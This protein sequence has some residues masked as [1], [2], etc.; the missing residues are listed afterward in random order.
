MNIQYLNAI[1]RELSELREAAVKAYHEA[2]RP[3]PWAAENSL[4][5]PRA[6][7]VAGAVIASIVD[8]K[9]YWRMFVDAGCP[10]P[11]GTPNEVTRE[12]FAAMDLGEPQNQIEPIVERAE[13]AK[14][15]CLVLIAAMRALAASVRARDMSACTDTA[16]LA[17]QAE[18]EA[19]EAREQAR[20]VIFGAPK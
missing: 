3:Y 7:E 1:A 12:W 9:H 17:T 20:A 2:G 8:A 18:K 16:A 10:D 19:E 11:V 4:A 5:E 15:Q 14:R 6:A 13:H